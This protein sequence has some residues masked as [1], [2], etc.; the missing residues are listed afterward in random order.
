M[1]LCSLF[2]CIPKQRR[3]NI[4]TLFLLCCKNFHALRISNIDSLVDGAYT[5]LNV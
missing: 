5:S 4:R 2:V 3:K 1:M